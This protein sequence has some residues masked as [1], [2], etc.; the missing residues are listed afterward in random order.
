MNNKNVDF[1]KKCGRPGRGGSENSDT[2][3]QG[4]RGGGKNGQKFADVLYEC[5]LM[6]NCPK[7]GELD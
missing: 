6:R 3:G 7:R 5:P 4:G 1:S 2:C